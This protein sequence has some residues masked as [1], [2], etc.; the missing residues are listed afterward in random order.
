MKE[1]IDTLRNRISIN[2]ERVWESFHSARTVR[3]FLIHS[4]F[5]NKESKLKT[6]TG[7]ME[8]LMEL[9]SIETPIRNAK[10]LL[11]GISVAVGEAIRNRRDVDE[12]ITVTLSEEVQ[13]SHLP[14]HRKP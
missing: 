4:Y 2:D 13:Q 3:N 5:K 9:V 10:E 6:R 1:L 14:S 7:R 8:M 12:D 11:N